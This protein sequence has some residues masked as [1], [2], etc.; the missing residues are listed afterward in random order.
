M[1][2]PL[3]SPP[4]LLL[5]LPLAAACA[6]TASPRPSPAVCAAETPRTDTLPSACQIMAR[7]VA[8]LGG[9][10]VIRGIQSI[11]YDAT[12]EYPA[13]GIK[14]D[15]VAYSARPNRMVVRATI[16]GIGEIAN[17]YDGTVAWSLAPTTGARL[18]EG[19]ELATARDNADFDALAKEP[20]RY[21]S[22]ENAG[23][24]E[25]EGRSA[26][27][28]RLVLQSGRELD[29]Y[30]DTVTGLQIGSANVQESG[31]NRTRVTTILEDYRPFGP[32]LLP[33]REIQRLPTGQE[34]VLT[35]TAVR[36][37]EVPDSV[38]ALPPQVRALVGS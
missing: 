28:V 35:R 9:R 7:H 34:T 26:W 37:N 30:Y 5:V 38:F 22:M 10:D 31:T 33:A 11:A 4:R 3:V 18:L 15:V 8:G 1:I 6:P 23:H 2:L 19:R 36:F 17:G 24:T 25:F 32:L 27:H 21:T 29:E 13:A 16:A 12:L 20:S 14:A